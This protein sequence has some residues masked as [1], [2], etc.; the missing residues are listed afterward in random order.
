ML[1]LGMALFLLV[2]GTGL[3]LVCALP[4]LSFL[5]NL[6]SIIGLLM[7]GMLLTTGAGVM[8]T[9]RDF[10]WIRRGMLLVVGLS[11]SFTLSRLLS[12]K[13]SRWT[14]LLRS[15]FTAGMM[16]T[17]FFPLGLCEREICHWPS[18]SSR[19]PCPGGFL[20]AILFGVGRN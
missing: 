12:R 9:T 5:A 7:K 8:S 19:I 14:L 3:L 1:A 16:S 6:Q 4:L 2:V 13:H 11:A 18:G 15:I 20:F 17:L 10:P